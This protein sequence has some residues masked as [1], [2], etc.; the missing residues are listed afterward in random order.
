MAEHATR[1]AKVEREQGARMLRL[2]RERVEKTRSMIATNKLYRTRLRKQTILTGPILIAIGIV[3]LVDVNHSA[4]AGGGKHWEATLTL[5]GVV[6]FAALTLYHA[7][8]LWEY[9]R[10]K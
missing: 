4:H 1:S 5:I 3:N 2:I 9:H 6:L 8:L 7:K 10:A